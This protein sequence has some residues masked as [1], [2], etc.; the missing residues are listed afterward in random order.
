MGLLSFL[1]LSLLL[2]LVHDLSFYLVASCITHLQ[3][4]NEVVNVDDY[5]AYGDGVTDDREAFEK[6]WKRACSS[7]FGATVVVPANKNYLL[8]PL[9]F[10]GPCKSDITMM[11]KG[12]IDASSNRS[13]WD[14]MSIRHWIMFHNLRNFVVTGGGTVNGNGKIWWQNSCKINRTLPCTVAPTALTF[15]GCKGLRIEDL[16]IKDSQQI[17]VSIEKCRDVEVSTLS[18]NAP[19]ESPN[20]DG[21]HIANT[22]NIVIS[23][24]EIRTGDDC[25][26][27]V[28][29]TRNVK[30]MNLFCGPGHGISIGSLG[31]NNSRDRV[32]NVFMDTVTLH[33]TQN[34]VRIK[35]WQGGQGYA[36]RII[37]QNIYVRNVH[38]PIII[39]QNYCDSTEPCPEKH[40]AVAISKVLFKNIKGTSASKVSVKLDCSKSVGCKKIMLQDINL[41]GEDGDSTESCC[42]NVRWSKRGTVVPPLC[43]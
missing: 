33:G 11:I 3:H 16:R 19:D 17:H 10:S 34:G 24:C 15:F 22:Q 40:R 42:K 20:T 29:G 43:V 38:N 18:I 1:L 14:G 32:S 36:R 30:G 2:I 8:K 26:S 6:A 35:T 5:G 28:S 23:D 21:I 37:F 13:D 27:I 31:A 9:L 12:T 25:V 4:S 39:D 7:H 41:V